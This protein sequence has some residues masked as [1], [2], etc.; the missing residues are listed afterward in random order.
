VLGDLVFVDDLAGAHTNLVRLLQSSVGNHARHRLQ[1][2]GGGREQITALVRA[3][4]GQLRVAAYHQALAREI[5]VRELVEV[6]LVE[7]A[8]LN[9]T[10]IDELS[11]RTGF[12][13]RDPIHA[14]AFV[15]GV[16]LFLRDHAA[17]PDQGHRHQREV[18]LQLVELVQ[19]RLGISGIALEHR[20]GHGTATRV[21]QQ[22][23][24]DL[25]LALLA[26]AR[27]P[28][29]RQRAALAFEIA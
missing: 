21:G 7:Q 16:D 19:Q 8:Q 23:V 12:Q 20:N 15:E 18:L 29:F 1:L 11:D 28:A 13:G 9:R 26:V 6:A 27:V 5:L 25:Q 24:V 22:P 4:L 10:G 17:V 2:R 3:Q 14:R